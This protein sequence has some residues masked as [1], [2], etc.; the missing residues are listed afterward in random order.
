MKRIVDSSVFFKLIRLVN[1][2]ARPFNEVIGKRHE[3]KLNEWRVM[4][5]L[6]SHPRCFATDVVAAAL[7]GAPFLSEEE[8]EV[9][10]AGM[11]IFRVGGQLS[12]D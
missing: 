6:A 10:F 1:L 11:F 4:V 2:T 5:V 9:D 12:G 3:L 7:R 8:F